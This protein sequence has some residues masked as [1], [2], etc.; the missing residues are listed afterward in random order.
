MVSM[1]VPSLQPLYAEHFL[2]PT[3]RYY[4]VQLR[5]RCFLLLSCCAT[6]YEF[7]TSNSI[8][9]S[10]TEDSCTNTIQHLPVTLELIFRFKC[11]SV[12]SES[13]IRVHNQ[14]QKTEWR[15]LKRNE[16]WLQRALA[17]TMISSRQFL[18]CR[19]AEKL[20]HFIARPGAV[21]LLMPTRSK[22]LY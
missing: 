14:I 3:S 4:L 6:T 12:I 8:Q 9:R 16:E 5:D 17:S 20:S 21:L 22:I 1:G 2:T 10:S 19:W 15:K 7:R 18:S 11:R 13:Q